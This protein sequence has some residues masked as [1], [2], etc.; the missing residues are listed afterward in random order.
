MIK[1]LI[2]WNDFAKIDLRVGTV[3]KA[4][5][6]EE[7][8]NPSYIITVDFGDLGVRRSSAQI[9]KL[10]EVDELVGR[11]VVCVVNFP[12]KQIANMQSEF[13]I[14]GAVNGEE[15]TLLTTERKVENGLKV[16]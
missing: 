15:V 14:L 13:L 4:E 8:R 16:G 1:E 6:F 12:K 7:A 9:T 11:Q 2:D 10:Y 3:V 5:P